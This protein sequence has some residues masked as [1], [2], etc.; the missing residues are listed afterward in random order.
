M[1]TNNYRNLVRDAA[2]HAKRWS[3]GSDHTVAAALRTRSGATVLGLNTYHFLGG[4]CGEVSALSNHAASRPDDAIVAVAAAYGAA[5]DVIAPCGK[6]RQILFDLDPGIECVV[7]T[8]NGLTSLAAR[9]L[10]PFGYD[11]R[12]VEAPQR[13]YMWEGYESTIRDGSKRQTI[14]IDDPF[15]PGPAELMF[16]KTSGETVTIAAEVTAVRAV[17]RDELSEDDARR[18][19]FTDL[20]ALHRALDQHYPGLAAADQVDIVSF[21]IA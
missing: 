20:D 17:A 16:E 15:R 21:T 2:D 12:A 19:G 4:P 6:C 11:W 8:A 13:I 5:G 14:R 9:E 7:R 10:L 1:L 3:D 18:D